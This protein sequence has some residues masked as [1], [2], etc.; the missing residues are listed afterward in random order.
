MLM[1]FREARE[2][3]RGPKVSR[4]RTPLVAAVVGLSMFSVASG[5]RGARSHDPIELAE[6][7]RLCAEAQ[8]APDFPL[9]ANEKVLTKVNETITQPGRVIW[10]H[11]PELERNRGRF[12]FTAADR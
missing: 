9:V 5:A 2:T 3:G 10:V 12:G 4:C 11:G 8:T 1:S 7:T 6:L